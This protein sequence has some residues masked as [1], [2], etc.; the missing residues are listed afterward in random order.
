MT[1]ER[2]E[3]RTESLSRLRHDVRTAVNQILGYS[4]LLLEQAEETGQEDF[5]PDLRR[6]QGAAR[7]LLELLDQL[8]AAAKA[9]AAT[10]APPAAPA[11]VAAPATER[12][13]DRPP[14]APQPERA[15]APAVDAPGTPARAG[16][17]EDLRT[18]Q[19][20]VLAAEPTSVG[21]PVA[22]DTER[23][24]RGGRRAGG[25]V[26]VVDDNE[27][28]RDMLSRRLASRG[29]SVAV[30]EDGH[31]ALD[32]IKARPFDLILL[33]VMM[34]GISGIDVLK[35]LRERFS[36]SDLPVIMATAKDASED[37]VEALKLGANDYVTKPLD[38][39]VVLARVQSQ[40]ALKHQR[41]EIARLAEDLEVRN[42]FIRN[43]FGRYL[44]D[45]VVESLLSTPEGLKLGGESRKVTILMTD[46]RGFTAISERMGPEQVVR[47][48]NN[49]LGA[50][51]E[52]ILRYQG[53]IDE[54]IG[55][56]ILAIF[57]APFSGEDDAQRAVACSIAM[58]TAMEE[59]N[60][61][62]RHEG[63]PRL[64]MGIAVHTGNVVVGNIGSQKRAKYGVVGPPVNIAG[65]I[66]SYTV[67]GQILVSEAT[68]AETGPIV[69]VAE[70]LSIVPKGA[71]DPITVFSVRGIGGE[72][73][74][75]LRDDEDVPV[76]LAVELPVRYSVVEGKYV[77]L[78]VFQGSFHELSAS[79]AVMRSQR[80]LRPLSNLKLLLVRDGEV[81]P[82]DVYAKVVEVSSADEDVCRIRFT[83]VPPGV[84]AYLAEL[85]ALARART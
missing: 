79:G 11:S 30:A 65:R 28:N 50:M 80:R 32:L 46:L 36:E 14:P 68:L 2:Q 9:A 39:P 4:E 83:S 59:V 48:L 6:I 58:Q 53:T 18:A 62:H 41:D 77:D 49:Y 19:F 43:T 40:L 82:G 73:N 34:P 37:I 29:Y 72:Y 70:R 63:L 42:R 61:Q 5:A 25:E 71:K 35:T 17:I 74:V 81:V 7:R 78:E 23:T 33:D 44:S 38:F 45:D 21:R 20:N 56:A 8:T 64:E 24:P 67:G 27:M 47:M 16:Q 69:T 84:D 10:A 13:P 54:F 57:G 66:E 1:E 3:T 26:L 85:L 15:P 76:P 75:H 52:V 60:V 55:D 51:A 12:S 22:P 31:R